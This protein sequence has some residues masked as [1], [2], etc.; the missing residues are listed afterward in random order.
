MQ[1]V[2]VLNKDGLPLMPTQRLGKVRHLLNEGKAK[3]IKRNPFT[4][5]LNYESGNFVQDATLGADYTKKKQEYFA[6]VKKSTDLKHKIELLNKASTDNATYTN[7]LLNEEEIKCS[8][9]KSDITN[10]IPSALAV[11][12]AEADITTEIAELKEELSSVN[13]AIEKVKLEL[14]ELQNS[15]YSVK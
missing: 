6:L 15:I 1:L 12:L 8:T 11:G 9:G 10:F 7:K 5:Q 4:I 2:Y 14:S 3:I 13:Q